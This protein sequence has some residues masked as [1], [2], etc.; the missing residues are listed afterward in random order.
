MLLTSSALALLDA[1]TVAVSRAVPWLYMAAPC[2]QKA[3]TSRTFHRHWNVSLFKKASTYISLVPKDLA[4]VERRI[5]IDPQ[6]A[7]LHSKSKRICNVPLGRWK[8][9]PEGLK[10]EQPTTG[11]TITPSLL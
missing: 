10:G 11:H 2:I 5:S 3:S 8:K 7:T 4:T 9:G 6:S 1:S